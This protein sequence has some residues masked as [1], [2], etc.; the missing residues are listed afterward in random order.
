MVGRT[1]SIAS[2]VAAWALLCGCASDQ[3]GGPDNPEPDEEDVD[4]EADSGDDTDVDGGDNEPPEID[5]PDPQ[6]VDEGATLRLTLSA[7][8]PEGA[9]VRLHVTGL[10][11]GARWYAERD[12]LVFQ[13]DF[14]QGGDAWEVEITADDG[15][16]RATASFTIA[17]NDTIQPPAPELLSS[18]SHDGYTRLAL[19][20]RTDEWLDSPGNAGRGFMA[21]VTGPTGDV[22]PASRPVRIMLHGYDSWPSSSGWE[23]EYRIMPHDPENTYWWGYAET[24]PE[25]APAISVPEYTQRRILHLLEWTLDTFPGAD[26]ARVY[27]EGASM[28]GAG[29]MTL[30]L[31]HAR[32]VAWV[33]ASIGQAIPRNHRPLRIEQLSTLWGAPEQN[34]P[35]EAG[36]TARPVWDAGDLTRALLESAEARDQFLYTKHGKDDPII[37]FGALVHASPATGR[38]LLDALQEARAGHYAIW[39]EGGHGEPDP[40]LGDR[41]WQQGWNPIF[42]DTSYL[43]RDLAFP[44]FSSS[45]LDDDPGDGEGNGAQAWDESSGFA[46]AID[47]AGDTGWN[48]DIAGAYNRFLRWDARALVD[49]IDGFE[50]PL[51][52]LNG[53]GAPAPAPGYPTLGD[54]VDGELPVTVDVTPRRVQAFRCQPGERVRWRFGED[55]G[56]V[57]ADADGSVTVPGLE[58]DVEWTTLTL[59][60]AD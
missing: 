9:A 55:E 19:R 26:P 46:G 1:G 27:V 29:A 25:R 57:T 15:D 21:Y 16:A 32:H 17:V 50:V 18:E 41:W 3:R 44:A 12:E 35:D 43:R 40:L 37:H 2:A 53:E 47:V 28:G 8:D 56:E 45:S 4:S 51:R 60:R 42:D 31:L 34:L 36:P 24:L 58:L 5:V 59:E 38:T 20:Q 11:P 30:G 13:P 7:S 52:A 39:D 48:G 6:Q 33:E 14:I 49:T 10:P 54:R 22:P 23:G